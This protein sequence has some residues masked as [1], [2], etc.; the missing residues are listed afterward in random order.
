LIKPSTLLKWLAF[1]GSVSI[2]GVLF[3]MLNDKELVENNSGLFY[4]LRGGIVFFCLVGWFASQSLISGRSVRAGFIG[5]GVHQF[6]APL[7]YFLSIHPRCANFVLIVSSIFIDL[8]GLF[9]IGAGVFGPS[10]KPFA[11]MI[12]LFLMRQVC[13]GF[14]ALP[15]PPGMI[16]RHPGFPSLLVTYHVANDFFFSGHTAIAVLGAIEA[17]QLYPLIPWWGG[18]AVC[19]VAVGEA[20]VV[21]VLRAHY[22]LDV[23][24][25]V[26]AAFCAAGLANWLAELFARAM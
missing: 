26:F 17:V 6:T 24:A 25:A 8:L 15:V 4:G 19:I 18:A 3:W 7:H 12:I 2:I 13:Q 23:I 5:D 16:W 10:M 11:A 1:L 14:C 20:L 21:L 22:T 9:L